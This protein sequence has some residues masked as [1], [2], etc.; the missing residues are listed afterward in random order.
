M[1]LAD[2]FW[3]RAATLK[4]IAAPAATHANPVDPRAVLAMSC[5]PTA[6][7]KASLLAANRESGPT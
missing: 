6:A 1:A 5:P 7:N 3:A 4:I 2:P